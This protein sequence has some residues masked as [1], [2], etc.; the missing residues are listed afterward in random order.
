MQ[1]EPILFQNMVMYTREPGGSAIDH[2]LPFSV[3][4]D[5]KLKA[6]WNTG[7]YTQN[8]SY[9]S[10]LQTSTDGRQHPSMHIEH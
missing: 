6:D 2:L 7:C 4:P 3:V 5:P 8:L 10:S 9:P 1:I